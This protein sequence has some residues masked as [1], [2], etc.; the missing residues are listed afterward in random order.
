MGF[1]YGF[2]SVHHFERLRPQ[3]A[4]YCAAAGA[5]TERIHLGPMGYTTA[6][7]DPMRI[8]E[9]AIVLDNVTHGRFEI[10]LTA[11]VTPDEFRVYQADWDTRA[12]RAMETMH[13]LKKAFLSPKPFDFSWPVP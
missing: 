13:L 2:T 5:R 1:E 10:G 8:V 7:Y 11:G 9:E 12:D 4:A 6:L 3:A